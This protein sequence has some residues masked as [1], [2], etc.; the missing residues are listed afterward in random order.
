MATIYDHIDGELFI[1]GKKVGLAAGSAPRIPAHYRASVT[2][3]VTSLQTAKPSMAEYLAKR[4]IDLDYKALYDNL[5]GFDGRPE[6]LLRMAHHVVFGFNS[7]PPKR[8]KTPLPL[9]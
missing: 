4:E 6:V 3:Q 1:D 5:A 7:E 9:P 2:I 8:D